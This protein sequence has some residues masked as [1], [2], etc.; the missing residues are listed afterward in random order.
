MIRLL[1]DP[2]G[3]AHILYYPHKWCTPALVADMYNISSRLNLLF[4]SASG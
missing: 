2:V 3:Y 4:N 1:P